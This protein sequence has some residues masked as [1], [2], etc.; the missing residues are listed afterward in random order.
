MMMVSQQGYL[1]S[2]IH[3]IYKC[4]DIRVYKMGSKMMMVPQDVCLL[5]ELH[6]TQVY[7]DRSLQDESEMMMVSQ[8]GCLLSGTL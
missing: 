8:D 2:E 7:K 5:S 4:K 1:L 3:S 6:F